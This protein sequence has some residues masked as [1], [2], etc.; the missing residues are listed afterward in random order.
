MSETRCGGTGLLNG[1]PAMV[2]DGP[3]GFR[4][5]LGGEGTVCAR[6]REFEKEPC[7]GCPGCQSSTGEFR[8]GRK[9]GRTIYAQLGPEPSDSDPL[10]GV[11][12]TP[13]LAARFVQA[14]ARALSAEEK[15]EQ[16]LEAL[17]RIVHTDEHQ[18]FAR[19]SMALIAREA[20]AKLD[21][22]AGK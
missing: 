18:G 8:T 21:G 14:E 15:V 16:A 11:M 17:R 2:W 20:L 3:Y 7:P 1:C 12:D 9:V 19:E 22:E 13:E 5:G 6:H 10:V 4:C